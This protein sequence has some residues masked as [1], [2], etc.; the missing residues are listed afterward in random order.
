[1]KELREEK[2][3]WVLEKGTLRT[4]QKETQVREC[5]FVLHGWNLM[6]S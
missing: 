3:Q 2:K 6:R 4:S 5:T 1:M